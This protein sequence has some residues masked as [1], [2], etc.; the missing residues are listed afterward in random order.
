MANKNIFASNRGQLTPQ[1]NA[2]N[3]AGGKAYAMTPKQALA[4]Y[5][6]TGCLNGTYYATASEQLANVLALCESIEPAFIARTAIWCRERGFMKDT[7]ALLCAVLAV[8]DVALLESVF[9]RVMNTP[10][11]LRNFVQIVRSGVTGRKSLGTAPKR[12]IRN[13]LE[14]AGNDVLFRG[15]VG[16]SPSLADVIRLSHPKPVSAETETLF[17]YLLGRPIETAKLPAIAR[18]YEEFKRGESTDVPD[19]PFEMLTSLP[20]SKGEW[21]EIARN[22]G[23]QM[24]RMNLNTFARHGVFDDEELTLTIATRLADAATIRKARVFPYQLMAAYRSTAPGVPDIV[25]DAL[26]DALEVA[27]ENVPEIEGKVYVFPDVSGSMSSPVT[28]VR[29][30]AT[31]AVRCIDVAALVAASIVRKN[32]DAAVLPFETRVVDVDLNR[33]DSVMTNAAKLAA[34]GG[35]GTTCSAPL[36]RLNALGAKGDLV[37]FVSDNESWADPQNGRGTATMQE[38]NAFRQRNPD[39][40][41]VCIDI[42]PYGTTQAMERTDV[43]NIGGFSDAVFGLVSEFAAGRLGGEHWVGVIENDN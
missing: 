33:R 36:A 40:R 43:L 37:I 24:T 19:V 9:P 1:T 30:G 32:P 26:Q 7:P 16:K 15:S 4:Q 20:L 38:W 10:K 11:M 18:T 41:M 6:A 35:G 3:E 13:W 12:M 39:A 5:A 21:K 23:W 34:V 8:K 22:A 29:K 25:R 28:G 42:Q 14:R 2:I 17:G 27:T 31:T